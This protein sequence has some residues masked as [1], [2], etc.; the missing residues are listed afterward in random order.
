LFRYQLSMT[1]WRPCWRMEIVLR[2]DLKML[3]SVACSLLN[4]SQHCRVIVAFK[5][6]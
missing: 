6:S 1:L 5:I 3:H 2:V 4:G